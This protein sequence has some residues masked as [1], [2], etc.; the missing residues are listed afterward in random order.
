MITPTSTSISIPIR[1]FQRA[2]NV[3]SFDLQDPR[4]CLYRM[5][6]TTIISSENTLAEIVTTMISEVIDSAVYF[7]THK[8][9]VRHEIN[10]EDHV[11]V[12]RNQDGFPFFCYHSEEAWH[13]LL[14]EPAEILWARDQSHLKSSNHHAHGKASI[15]DAISRTNYSRGEEKFRG[16]DSFSSRCRESL[17]TLRTTVLSST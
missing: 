10:E 8:T 15:V 4:Y 6:A 2:F 17:Q 13:F 9:Y 16:R 14:Q 1:T 3:Q 11:S 5:I 12:I 7:S